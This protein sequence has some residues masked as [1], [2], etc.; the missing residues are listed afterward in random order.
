VAEIKGVGGG[1]D[2]AAGFGHFDAFLGP[3]A[4]DADLARES[5]FGGGEEGRPEDTVEAMGEMEGLWGWYRIISLPIKWTSTGQS[6][7]FSLG[8]CFRC[9]YSVRI[10]GSDSSKADSDWRESTFEEVDSSS[11]D[12]STADSTSGKSISD[13][14]ETLSKSATGSS[15]SGDI[16]VLSSDPLVSS[17]TDAVGPLSFSPHGNP[18]TVR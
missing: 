12:P 15:A 16:E 13:V 6:V 2:V 5:E 17:D 9:E 8:C 14:R 4:V 11:S 3:V 18:V 10:S 1:D 7:G